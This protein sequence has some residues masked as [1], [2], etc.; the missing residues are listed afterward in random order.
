MNVQT[1][2]LVRSKTRQKKHQKDRVL[3]GLR[4][5]F[6]SITLEVLHT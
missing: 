4:F 1:N 5:V 3:W 6:Q 2:F